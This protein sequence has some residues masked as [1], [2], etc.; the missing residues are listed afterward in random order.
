MSRLDDLIDLLQSAN[1]I[2]LINPSRNVRSAFIQ[3]DDLCEL[4]MKSWLQIDTE[5]R[6]KNCQS[7]LEAAS[8]ITTSGHKKSLQEFFLESRSQPD[9]EKAIGISGNATKKASLDSILINYGHLED[10]LHNWKSEIEPGRYKSFHQVANEI[11]G[12]KPLP[13]HQDLHDALSR[14]ND[15]RANRNKF[16]H[17]HEQSGLTVNEQQCLM[18]FLDLYYLISELFGS[19]FAEK[20]ELSPVVQ[21]QLII[22]KLKNHAYRATAA[23]DEYRQILRERNFLK[24]HPESFGYEL[25]FLY[26][27]AVTFVSTIRQHFQNK[28]VE[29]QI[30]IDAINNMTRKSHERS[31][32]LSQRQRQ[33]DILKDVI[34][35]CLQ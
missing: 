27:D 33:V 20:L 3:V 19:T 30:R 1:E 9:L 32:E 31:S 15:R 6:Q 24:V 12:R 17:S 14:I 10:L 4:A 7:D 18:A 29:H 35:S 23:Y 28:I 21:A 25:C 34:D 5:L 11:E 22:M 13:T 16:F 8:V 2:Y 26:E